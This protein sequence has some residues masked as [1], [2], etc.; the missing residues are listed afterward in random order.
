KADPNNLTSQDRKTADRILTSLNGTQRITSRKMFD[1]TLKWKE[2]EMWKRLIKQ[3]G[4]LSI[5]VFG[6]ERFIE[7]WKVFGFEIILA[8]NLGL[9][10]RIGFI[11]ALRSRA[12]PD[13]CE[14]VEA[15]VET[16]TMRA[17]S[18][19]TDPTKEDIPMLIAL[20]KSR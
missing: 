14:Q 9:G 11:Q 8:D 10:T 20:G 18:S 7:A 3:C 16:Q 4:A 12:P 6:V 19:F 2:I 1:Y 13:V 5:S 15:W 17:V